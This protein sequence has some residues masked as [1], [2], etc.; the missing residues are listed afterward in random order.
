MLP[1]HRVRTISSFFDVH[2]IV[3]GRYTMGAMI[4]VVATTL[5]VMDSNPVAPAPDL[6]DPP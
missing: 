4:P 1:S 6:L 5:C 3:V 2:Q